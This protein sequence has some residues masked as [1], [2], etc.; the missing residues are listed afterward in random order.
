[1]NK[2]RIKKKIG[3]LKETDRGWKWIFSRNRRMISRTMLAII[4]LSTVVISTAVGFRRHHPDPDDSKASIRIIKKRF[5]RRWGCKWYNS[6][7]EWKSYLGMS[8]WS[9]AKP[10]SENFSCSLNS[11]SLWTQLRGTKRNLVAENACRFN[12]FEIFDDLRLKRFRRSDRYGQMVC[13]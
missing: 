8:T 4:S 5:G 7:D 2:E 11:I 6:A 1:M 3:S 13:Y 10:T 12:S 9:K